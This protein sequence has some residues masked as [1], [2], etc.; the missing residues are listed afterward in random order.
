MK[1][2]I[3]QIQNWPR[4]HGK[5][6][7]ATWMKRAEK[8]ESKV[9]WANWQ[10]ETRAKSENQYIRN[11]KLIQTPWKKYKCNVNEEKRTEDRKQ[12]MK[13]VKLNEETDEK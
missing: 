11:S 10:R 6:I 12:K 1:I 13:K 5:N 7:N 2:N 4:I 8:E 9:K 3:K